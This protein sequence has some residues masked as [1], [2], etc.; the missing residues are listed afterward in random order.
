MTDSSPNEVQS[1]NLFY[2][3]FPGSLNLP[4]PEQEPVTKAEDASVQRSGSVRLHA[5]LP[6]DDVFTLPVPKHFGGRIF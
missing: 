3:K 6:K 2:S 1:A 5:L 4:L